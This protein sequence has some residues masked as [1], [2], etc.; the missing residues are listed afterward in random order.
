MGARHGLPAGLIL[1]ALA[2]ACSSDPE[3]TVITAPQG[4]LAGQVGL[5]LTPNKITT[6]PVLPPPDAPPTADEIPDRYDQV[7][8]HLR[9]QRPDDAMAELRRIAKAGAVAREILAWAR[10]DEDLLLLR[11]RPDY[12]ALMYPDG[13]RPAGQ[14]SVSELYAL[15][16]PARLT[17]RADGPVLE[18]PGLGDAPAEGDRW[19]PIT[20]LSWGNVANLLSATRALSRAGE[21]RSYQPAPS[22]RDLESLPIAVRQGGVALLH[23]P[24]WWRPRPGTALFVVPYQLGGAH[25]GLGVAVYA[26]APPGVR[27][28]A[29]SGEIP[30]PC[31]SRDALLIT[32]SVEELRVVAGCQGT[33]LTACR[34]RWEAGALRSACGGMMDAPPTR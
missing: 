13:D 11:D 2:G 10:D 21:G 6:G 25:G 24:G 8:E 23:Q 31:E 19:Q 4:E 29:A 27:L 3:P 17:H 22:N 14:V 30:L 26:P 15:G 18:I 34:L 12:Q 33:S 1:C 32:D 7:R 28:V 9:Q 16:G 20:S 5:P